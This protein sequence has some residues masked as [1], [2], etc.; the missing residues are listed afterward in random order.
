MIV[1]A[2]NTI[3]ELVT[4]MNKT[5]KVASIVDNIATADLTICGSLKWLT[6]GSRLYHGLS[7]RDQVFGLVTSIFGQVVSVDKSAVF[8]WTNYLPEI[9]TNYQSGTKN[10][11]TDEWDKRGSLW[12]NKLPIIILATPTPQSKPFAGSSVETEMQC[13]MYFLNQVDYNLVT[14]EHINTVIVPPIM[15]MVQE[16]K[17]TVERTPWVNGSVV[18]YEDTTLTRFSEYDKNG[19]QK[20]IIDSN[21]GGIQTRFSLAVFK[22]GDEC[23]IC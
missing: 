2:A 16:F 9:M 5:V 18:S 21:L 6:V 8:D 17:T 1:N 7:G 23:I 14:E 13:L 15:A 19:E 3:S 22:R 20:A 10:V 11:V 12:S 4:M